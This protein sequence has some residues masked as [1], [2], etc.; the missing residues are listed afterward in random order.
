MITIELPFP[1]PELNPNFRPK[2]WS[3]KAEAI[4]QYRHDCKVDALQVVRSLPLSARLRMDADLPIHVTIT[5]ILKDR[6]RHDWDNLLAS[7]KALIDGALVDAGL[8]PDDDVRSWSPTLRYEQGDKAA[9]RIEL[10][11]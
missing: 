7:A 4:A 8:L 9:V 11:A 3:E 6:R 10:G 2:H 1:P 5:F